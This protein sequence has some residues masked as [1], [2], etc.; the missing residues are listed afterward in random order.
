MLDRSFF[1]GT[2]WKMNK[3]LAEGLEFSRA[4][5]DAENSFH[6]SIR[7]FIVPPFT[8]LREMASV[9]SGCRTKVGA[10]NMHWETTGQWTG[11]I[12]PLMLTDCD[13][14]FVEI[15]HSERR[16]NFNETDHSVGL[17]VASA[18]R[19]GLVPVMCIGETLAIKDAGQTDFFLQNQVQIGLSELKPSEKNSPIVIAYE[20]IWAI[21]EEGTPASTD[22]AAK[23]HKSISEVSTKILG[24]EPAVIYGGSVNL[25]NCV[26]LIE[27]PEIN[28]LFIGRAALDPKGFIDI[29]SL[30]SDCLSRQIKHQ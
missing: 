11:E 25:D 3:T 14:D 5:A 22:Y 29:V 16:E 17:K 26:E 1:I 13:L 8:I 21:G 7:P 24:R 12:S 15:G 28:G 19:H 4:L 20:P 6:S 18:V 9:L 2:G 30:V 27:Q 10:Q 23:R